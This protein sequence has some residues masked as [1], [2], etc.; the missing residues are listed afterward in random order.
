MVGPARAAGAF[1]T[2]VSF[3]G[4]GVT[5]KRSYFRVIY[6]TV[7]YGLILFMLVGYVLKNW[8]NARVR[9][10]LLA[11][12]RIADER[13]PLVKLSRQGQDFYA[14]LV[15]SPEKVRRGFNGRLGFLPDLRL[16]AAV[17]KPD[18]AQFRPG[19][20]IF[21]DVGMLIVF[22]PGEQP[23][24]VLTEVLIDVDVAFVKADGW[25]A[26][27]EHVRRDQAGTVRSEMRCRYAL[28]MPAGRLGK[29]A[30]AAGA[31][32]DVPDKLVPVTTFPELAASLQQQHQA[33]APDRQSP[34]P[35]LSKEP[36]GRPKEQKTTHTD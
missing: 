28:V 11:R 4:S 16:C 15:D 17:V 34:T 24:L 20:E 3:S 19:F 22:P 6:R 26:Q 30:I 7:T 32:F 36:H 31:T 2:Q 9:R 1:P 27:I 29:H 5:R 25:V 10:A 14:E 12:N 21:R 8:R 23:A 35:T 13:A 33:G 18:L